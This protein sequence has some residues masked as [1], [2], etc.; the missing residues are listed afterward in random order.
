VDAL[1]A[2]GSVLLYDVVGTAL[3]EAP[4]LQNT[5]EFMQ[6]LGAPWVFGSDTPAAL[7]TGRGWTASVTDMAVPGNAWKRWAHPPI[8]ADVPSAPRG[9]FIEASKA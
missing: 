7:V 5:I 1:S 4:F 6:K 9:Y 8:P 2:S 3:L